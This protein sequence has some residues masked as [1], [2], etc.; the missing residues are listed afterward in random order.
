MKT[1]RNGWKTPKPF[2]IFTFEYENLSK[3]GKAEHENELELI[4]YQ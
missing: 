1:N 2:S 4:E 3:S